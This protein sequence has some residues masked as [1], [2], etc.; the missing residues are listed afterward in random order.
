MPI[1]TI[2]QAGSSANYGYE[3]GNGL[4][5]FIQ[6]IAADKIK[7]LHENQSADKI[8]KAF[9]EMDPEAAEW[10]STLESKDQVEALKNMYEKKEEKPF[11][12]ESVTPQQ[13]DQLRQAMSHP[14][15]LKQLTEEQVQKL[16]RYLNPSE[17]QQA[18]EDVTQNRPSWNQ[19]I[20]EQLQM[21]P[22]M[23][24][25]DE[26][27]E[28]KI[29]G[30]SSLVEAGSGFVPERKERSSVQSFP[31]LRHG[32]KGEANQ[33]ESTQPQYENMPAE[34]KTRRTLLQ[35]PGARELEINKVVEQEK[36]R[37][38]AYK[39]TKEERKQFLQDYQAS[40]RDLD[41]LNRF[42]ELEKDGKLD[43]PGYV[44][45][46]KRSGLDIPAL[47]NPESEEFQKIAAN[48]LRDAKNYYGGRVS[49]M[50][51]E[52]FLKTIPSLSQ[53]PDG[54]KRVI[55]NLKNLARA[56][57]E[58]YQA[59][60]DIKSETRG[61]IPIDVAEQVEDRIDKRMDHL[62]EQFRKDLA[63]EV[64]AG[65]NKMITALQA[66]LG[67]AA[68]RIPSSIGKAGQGALLGAGVGA[69]I[70][71]LPGAATGAGI[72]GIGGAVGGLLGL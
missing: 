30:L 42:Q 3:A 61:N 51:M 29:P 66:A 4:T 40:K 46:L 21:A 27:F 32:S 44:E 50:E 52:Q 20:G 13:K 67:S 63:K 41:D 49:N 5:S 47:L 17:D 68:G 69:R 64:P 54:R 10:I 14:E 26:K 71:G 31:E 16:Q 1:Q 12:L 2:P 25:L 36:L 22:G 62:A 28:S 38:N 37:Q 55:A 70:G 35:K 58:R 15:V 9:P 8:R 56:K 7:K 23:R 18:Q 19:N 33:I 45:F 34:A 57:T 24:G 53:S 11:S 43:T 65:Q 39:E 6:K 48:F 60:K 59:Y 72:G